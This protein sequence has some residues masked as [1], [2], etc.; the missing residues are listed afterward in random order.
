MALAGMRSRRGLL[1][2]EC[3]GVDVVVTVT[4]SRGDLLMALS[5]LPFDTGDTPALFPE[6]RDVEVAVLASTLFARRRLSHRHDTA[7]QPKAHAAITSAVRSTAHAVCVHGLASV[8]AATAEPRTKRV[9]RTRVPPSTAST[10]GLGVG[11]GMGP[12]VRS[13]STAQ[14]TVPHATSV[15]ITAFESPLSGPLAVRA[16]VVMRARMPPAD[17]NERPHPANL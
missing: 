2:P 16:T 12:G 15:T 8:P 7:T 6:S 3:I 14:S 1:G 5:Q 9:T 17:A 4:P 11:G 10:H 13:S